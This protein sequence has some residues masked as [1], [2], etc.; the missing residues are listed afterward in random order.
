MAIAMPMVMIMPMVMTMIISALIL[1]HVAGTTRECRERHG[2]L[3]GGRVD[4]KGPAARKVGCLR[5]ETLFFLMRSE[6]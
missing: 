5:I 4:G 2:Q 6:F 3:N 1:M